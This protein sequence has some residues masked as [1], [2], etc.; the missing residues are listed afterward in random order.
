MFSAG[1]WKILNDISR[2]KNQQVENWFDTKG[3]RTQASKSFSI[4]FRRSNFQ[5]PVIGDGICRSSKL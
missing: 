1:G 3:T 2:V 4:C 5:Y